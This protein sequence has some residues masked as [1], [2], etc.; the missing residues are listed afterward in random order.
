MPK[1]R[2]DATGD[3]PVTPETG[4]R[5]D[6][7]LPEA[8]ADDPEREPLPA[9]GAESEPPA[10]SAPPEPADEPVETV[11]V[12]EAYPEEPAPTPAAATTEE[13]REEPAEEHHEEE[14]MSLASRFLIL[15]LLLFAG[16]ALGIWGAPKLAPMLPS[17]LQPVADWLSPGARD[18]EAELA[19]LRAQFDERVGGVESRF[20]DL[21]SGDEIDQRI[22]AAVD[23]TE[24][25][26][27][28]EIGALQETVSASDVGADVRQRLDRVDSALE[29]QA[30]ELAN[31]K[32]QLSGATAASGQ[33]NDEAVAKIDVYQAEVD[34]LR[35]EMAAV[36]DKVAALA[37]RLDQVA[38]EANRQIQTAQSQVGEIQQQ[39]DTALGAAE[40]GADV[41]LIRAAV[42]SGQ[43]FEEPLQRL[44]SH[45]ETPVPEG[46]TAAA[47]T[48][49]ETMA[50]LR[51]S[52]PDAAHA[53]IRASILAGA[54]DG[55]LA[56]SR[57]YLEA[58]VASRSLTPQQGQG[59]D[60]VLSRMEDHLRQDDLRGVLAEAENL[61]SEAAAAMSGWLDAARLRADAAAGLAGL[62]TG[63]GA[64]N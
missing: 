8:T 62:D 21:T 51:A 24:T 37:T 12:D 28:A 1:R 27:A 59:T 10:A 34:G 2:A 33:L 57:A 42:A 43:P 9:A 16:A 15:L 3:D 40:I 5:E 39:A 64:G 35:A 31:L 18:A 52:Y 45:L 63:S 47:P 56:R 54:G 14:G 19:A 11:T 36:S 46:L 29:G 26:L 49:V 53:A 50:E 55:V 13:V 48:G 32:D 38:A 61:P 23:A 30:A 60:A 6:E 41:A 25:R 17:G 20:A 7:T 58:Q 44:S 4:G 22:S